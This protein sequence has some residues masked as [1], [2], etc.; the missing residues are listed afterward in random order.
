MFFLNFRLFS[1]IKLTCETLGEKPSL[2]VIDNLNFLI[3]AGVDAEKVADFMHYCCSLA[4]STDNVSL[5]HLIHC[6]IFSF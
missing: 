2:L 1:K 4:K 5:N 3:N 6:S